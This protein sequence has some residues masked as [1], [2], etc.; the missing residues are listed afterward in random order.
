VNL[1]LT[2]RLESPSFDAEETMVNETEIIEGLYINKPLKY[3]E[4]LP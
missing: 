1:T 4:K 2:K 3:F